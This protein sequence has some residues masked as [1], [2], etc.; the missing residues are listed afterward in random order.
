MSEIKI[1][2]PTCGKVLRLQDTP[3]INAAYFTCPVCKER[4]MVGNCQRYNPAPQPSAQSGDETRYGSVGYQQVDAD[5]TRTASDS[6]LGSGD[7]TRVGV[8]PQAKVGIL[9]D[10]NGVSY[11]LAVGF[12]T[13]GR[14]A[15]TSPASVQIATADRTMSRNHAVIEVRNAGGQLL[16]ILKNGA[17][18]NPSYLNNALVAQGDQLI[19][20]NGDRLTMGKTVLTFKKQEQIK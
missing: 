8:A 18:K 2:C 9:V 1:K 5:K 20:N 3:N 4:H 17:N 13:I 7:E 15:S 12:N 6:G 11:Q 19:L 10:A 16:H 14:K